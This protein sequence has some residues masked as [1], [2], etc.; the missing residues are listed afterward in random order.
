VIAV[1]NSN[2]QST[3]QRC[4][5]AVSLG[6]DCGGDVQVS[7]AFDARWQRQLPDGTTALITRSYYVVA[8]QDGGPTVGGPHVECQTEY[9]VCTDPADPGMT[10]VWADYTYEALPTTAGTDDQDARR[11][12]EAARPATDDEWQMRVSDSAAAWVPGPEAEEQK[13]ESRSN[14]HDDADEA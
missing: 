9:L 6:G 1:T 7:D 14:G 11:A 3:W 13:P 10:E 5:P 8:D 12:A 4:E 2:D